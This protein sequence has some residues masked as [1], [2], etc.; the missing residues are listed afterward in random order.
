MN[1]ETEIAL[2][3]E[4]EWPMQLLRKFVFKLQDDVGLR[5][6][7]DDRRLLRCGNPMPAKDGT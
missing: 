3:V 7:V 4:A 5:R 2:Q 6:L 1:L